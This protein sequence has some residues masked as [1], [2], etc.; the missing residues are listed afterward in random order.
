MVRKKM[1]VMEE[2]VIAYK[3]SKLKFGTL[4][5][6]KNEHKLSSRIKTT[7]K[8]LLKVKDEKVVVLIVCSEKWDLNDEYE[9][10]RPEERYVCVYESSFDGVFD[11]KLIDNA[12]KE[13]VF[14]EYRDKVRLDNSNKFPAIR[15]SYC[16]ECKHCIISDIGTLVSMCASKISTNYVT[17]E[18]IVEYEDCYELNKD[19]ECNSFERKEM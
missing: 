16:N 14:N 9:N 19:G 18:K 15:K 7:N 3:L 4:I 8:Y 13:V 2:E 10:A 12:F 5:F 17:G 1:K 6:S 11:E